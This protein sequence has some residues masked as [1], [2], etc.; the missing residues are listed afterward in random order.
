MQRPDSL[1]P[2]ALERA[3]GKLFSE[4]LNLV[5]GVW[6]LCHSLNSLSSKQVQSKVNS[7]RPTSPVPQAVGPNLG[8]PEGP[9]LVLPTGAR[10]PR[11]V[12]R[13]AWPPARS[14]RVKAGQLCRPRGQARP[15]GTPVWFPPGPVMG[16]GAVDGR[17][18]CGSTDPR[19]NPAAE[20]Y[21]TL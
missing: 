14:R 19:R 18:G 7:W 2:T 17:V 20:L 11:A 9:P 13:R 4:G 8:R 3:Q 15:G 5:Q 12:G 10:Q 6:T 1:N 16:R 21:R